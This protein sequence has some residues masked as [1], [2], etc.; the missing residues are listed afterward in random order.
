MVLIACVKMIKEYLKE[1]LKG[2]LRLSLQYFLVG[3]IIAL[4]AI[5]YF[6]IVGWPGE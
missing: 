1:Y 5:T 3:V 4:A 2:V 6:S